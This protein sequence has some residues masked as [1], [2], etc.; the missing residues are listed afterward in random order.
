MYLCTC[1]KH[2][3]P[4]KLLVNLDFIQAVKVTKSTVPLEC[5]LI[6]ST[7]FSILDSRSSKFSRIKNRVSRLEFR[8]SIFEVREPSF[9][10]RVSSFEK[11]EVF[12]KDLEQRFRGNN[13]ILGNK[14]IAMNKTIDVWLYSYKPSVECMLFFSCCAAN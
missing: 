7:R 8:V 1:S 5:K 6:V 2:T 11:L 12:F 3:V 14:T 13:L 4:F 10:D 9:K